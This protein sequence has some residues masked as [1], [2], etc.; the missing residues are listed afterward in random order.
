MPHFLQN[1]QISF[2]NTSFTRTSHSGAVFPFGSRHTLA[3]ARHTPVV[4]CHT[5]GDLPPGRSSYIPISS[6]ITYYF[7]STEQKYFFRHVQAKLAFVC[8]V[9][10]LSLNEIQVSTKT[11]IL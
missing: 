11:Q 10:Y 6:C 4:G 3:S 9:I 1:K 8:G 2:H 5:L 7:K